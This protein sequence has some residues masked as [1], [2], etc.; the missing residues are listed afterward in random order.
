MDYRE[1]LRGIRGVLLWGLFLLTIAVLLMGRHAHARD[2]GGWADTSPLVR[3]WFSELMQPD[4]PYVSCC[5]ES[6]AYEAD[7]YTVDGDTVVAIITDERGDTFPN[8]VTRPHIE[9][10]TKVRIPPGKVKF[11]AGN[12]TGH[13][14]LFIGSGG[15]YC[16]VA[17]GGA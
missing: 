6:D 11:D 5:G 13:G 4:N 15:V 3:K 10:G 16:Y 7:E 12:P 17:P 8:G 14:I 1:G 2:N 9:P